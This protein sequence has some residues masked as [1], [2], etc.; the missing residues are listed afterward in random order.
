MAGVVGTHHMG[1][2][3]GLAVLF[4]QI[5]KRF[6]DQGLKLAALFVRERADGRKNVSIDLRREFNPGHGSCSFL[7]FQ[8]IMTNHELTRQVEGDPFIKPLIAKERNWKPRSSLRTKTIM[9]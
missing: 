2:R 9:P 1:T 7:G 3:P 6:I 4:D 8:R 5:G